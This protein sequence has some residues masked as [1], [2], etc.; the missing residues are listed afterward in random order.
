M[1]HALKKVAAS[2]ALIA[3]TAFLAA[4]S[5]GPSEAEFVAA[6]IK[7]GAMGANSSIFSGTALA[8]D[9]RRTGT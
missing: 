4:C 8:A 5:R 9:D 3:L 6:C 1:T 7:D 2:P